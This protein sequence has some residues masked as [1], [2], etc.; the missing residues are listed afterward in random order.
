MHRVA[1]RVG[2]ANEAVAIRIPESEVRVS[3]SQKLRFTRT[4]HFV[5]D[6]A[7]GTR[8][9]GYKNRYQELIVHARWAEKVAV[10]VCD[11]ERH[12]AAVCRVPMEPGAA[13]GLGARLLEEV[14]EATVKCAAD[15]VGVKHPHT[16]AADIHRLAGIRLAA[17]RF[18]HGRTLGTGPLVSRLFM[19]LFPRFLE[20]SLRE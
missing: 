5:F 2:N 3:P 17:S 11:D 20:L 14:E 18:G 15:Q 19:R 10:N 4:A 7:S 16:H 6:G 13:E 8:Q 1:N 12:P 9:L